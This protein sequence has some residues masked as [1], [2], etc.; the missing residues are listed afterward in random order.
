MM[1]MSSDKVEVAPNRYAVYTVKNCDAAIEK[2]KVPWSMRRAY[3]ASTG[4]LPWYD[5]NYA[6]PGAQKEE[7]G[8]LDTFFETAIYSQII[9]A[10]AVDFIKRCWTFNLDLRWSPELMLTHPWLVSRPKQLL[11]QN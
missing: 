4:I 10:N 11:I 8:N 5:L 3:F 1:L 6:K 7:C 9:S 2:A